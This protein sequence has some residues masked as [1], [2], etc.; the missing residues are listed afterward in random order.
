MTH[1]TKTDLGIQA[2]I[3]PRTQPSFSLQNRLLRLVWAIAY[4]LLF[5]PSPRPLHRWRAFMLRCFGAK[6]G[7]S[8]HVYPSVQIWAPWNLELADQ[9]GIADGVICYSMAPIVIGAQVVV[10]Q[11][12]HLCTGSHDYE[13]ANF[14]LYARPIHIEPNVWLCAEC[15]VGPGVTVGTGAVIGARAVVTKNMPPWNV[16]GGNP[17]KPIKLRVM[18]QEK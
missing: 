1:K 2:G 12:V 8:C 6:L 3:D 16:C 14:Q 7:H 4:R 9:V 15:F 11:G 13:D 17:C 5:R 10:S 18:R